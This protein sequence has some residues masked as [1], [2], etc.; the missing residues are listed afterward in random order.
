MSVAE[1]PLEMLF[2]LM[3]GMLLIWTLFAGFGF[4]CVVSVDEATNLRCEARL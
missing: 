1:Q 2:R 4:A 3:L